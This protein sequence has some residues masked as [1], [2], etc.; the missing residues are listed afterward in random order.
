[1]VWIC[2]FLS[3]NALFSANKVLT[4]TAHKRKMN[5]CP[6]VMGKGVRG[7]RAFWRPRGLRKQVAIF[8]FVLRARC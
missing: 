2:P 7:G 3:R 5:T 6:R 8:T 4:R 1:M